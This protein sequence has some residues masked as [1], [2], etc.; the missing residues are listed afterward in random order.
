MDLTL[1]TQDTEITGEN[2]DLGAKHAL[3]NAGA[4]LFSEKGYLAVSTRELT[5]E[6]GVNL[7]SIQYHFGSK[8]K[9]FIETIRFLFQ[10]RQLGTAAYFV[11]QRPTDS[12]EHAAIEIAFFITKLL[13]DICFPLGP[14]VCKLVNREMLGSVAADPEISEA[15]VSTIADEFYGPADARLQSCISILAPD[16]SKD[17]LFLRSK[18]II[19]QCTFYATNKA[20]VQ[21]LHGKD[22]SQPKTISAVRDNIVEFSLRGLGMS[23]EEIDSVKSEVRNFEGS[24]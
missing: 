11:Y 4:R 6:A 23:R 24:K 14:D 15:L 20:F 12:R 1:S 18:S 21:R 22:Y 16:I 19:G 10:Q 5:E 2:K 8:S 9:L 3:L 13:N 17:Q 7:G